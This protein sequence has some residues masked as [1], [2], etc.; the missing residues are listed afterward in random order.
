MEIR[1]GLV[2]ALFLSVA[3]HAPT[4]PVSSAVTVTFVPV[5]SV[6]WIHW[7]DSAAFYFVATPWTIETRDTLRLRARRLCW[8]CVPV[9]TICRR[10]IVAAPGAS[11]V[12]QC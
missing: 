9:R 5:P 8:S 10:D 2:S 7:N 6:W 3:C 1:A 4:I 12:V 11:V